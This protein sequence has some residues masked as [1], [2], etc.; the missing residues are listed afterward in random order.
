MSVLAVLG[1]RCGVGVSLVAVSGSHSL[2]AVLR[3]LIS[4]A[5]RAAEHRL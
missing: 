2:S 5:S 3:F 1:L 4:V